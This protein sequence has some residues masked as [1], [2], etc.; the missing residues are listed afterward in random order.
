MNTILTEGM[1]VKI[2]NT[3]AKHIVISSDPYL[4]KLHTDYEFCLL[5]LETLEPIAIGDNQVMKVWDVNHKL[6]Y[7]AND[8]IIVSLK[9][10]VE[11][12]TSKIN[13]LEAAKV[14]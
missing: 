9:R 3:D 2:A 12:I 8:S 5:N 1:I 10:Q 4:S 14:L 11:S 13:E 6:V 7:D